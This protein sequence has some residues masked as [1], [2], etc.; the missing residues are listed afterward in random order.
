MLIDPQ[1]AAFR[2]IFK[3]YELLAYLSYRGPK[4]GYRCIELPTTRRYPKGEIPTKISG[5]RGNLEVL[6]TLFR[7]CVGQFNP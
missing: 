5:F 3:A 1:I 6:K 2:D 7:V 4:L